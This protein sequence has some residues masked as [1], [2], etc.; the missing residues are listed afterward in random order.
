MTRDWGERIKTIWKQDESA[1][2]AAAVAAVAAT[3]AA[4]AAAAAA[5]AVLEAELGIS[6]MLLA[7]FLLC[8]RWIFLIG[9]P[10]FMMMALSHRK[11][12]RVS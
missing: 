8:F 1:A 4:A 10:N 11:R 12:N 3:F 7:F 5:A 9:V 6:Q 2:V